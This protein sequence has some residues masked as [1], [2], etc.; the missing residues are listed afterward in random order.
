MSFSIQEFSNITVKDCAKLKSTSFNILKYKPSDLLSLTLI[1]I[2]LA[3]PGLQTSIKI[4]KLKKGIREDDKNQS[5]KLC[6]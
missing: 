5:K 6:R 3:N 4:T 2:L 1:S